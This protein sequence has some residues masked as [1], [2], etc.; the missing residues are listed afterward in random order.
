VNIKKILCPHCKY[1]FNTGKIFPAPSGDK[2]I[3]YC[4]APLPA[5]AMLVIRNKE[6]LPLHLYSISGDKC[7]MFKEQ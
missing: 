3:E 7:D 4:Q 1:H 5:A 6:G 2:T